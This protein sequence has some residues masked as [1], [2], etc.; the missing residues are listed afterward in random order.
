MFVSIGYWRRKVTLV[1][2][3]FQWSGDDAIT[4]HIGGPPYHVM[5]AQQ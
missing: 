4:K 5:A 3:R 1:T 2:A